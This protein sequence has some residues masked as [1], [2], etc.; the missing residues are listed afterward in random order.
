MQMRPNQTNKFLHNKETISKTKR[1]STE[2]R[3]YLQ[4]MEPTR[5]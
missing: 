1:Q 4:A 5:A 2:Q 3:K